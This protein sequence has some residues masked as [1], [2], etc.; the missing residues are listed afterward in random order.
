MISRSRCIWAERKMERK[1]RLSVKKDTFGINMRQYCRD[2]ESTVCSAVSDRSVTS[3]LIDLHREKIRI[4]QRN[5]N[6]AKKPVT[7]AILSVSAGS[8]H[9][10][11]IAANILISI[12]PRIF[13]GIPSRRT[14]MNFW[15]IFLCR[16]KKHLPW[17]KAVKWRTPKPLPR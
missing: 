9:P 12:L 10:Q 8:M 13:D 7:K 14:M 17:L 11:V 6:C 2:H 5:A 3:E 4:L 1:E 15:P 16:W